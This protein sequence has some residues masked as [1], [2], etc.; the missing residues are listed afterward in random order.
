MRPGP[1]ELLPLRTRALPTSRVVC[2]LLGAREWSARSPFL[3]MM[4]HVRF[5]A[6]P[7]RPQIAPRTETVAEGPRRTHIASSAGSPTREVGAPRRTGLAKISTRKGRWENHRVTGL[8]IGLSLAIDRYRTYAHHLVTNRLADRLRSNG[9]V[10]G[11]TA[12][13]KK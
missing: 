5:A 7:F 6:G 11:L 9:K 12:L 10:R 2:W 4:D 1:G 13:R 3:T 8:F